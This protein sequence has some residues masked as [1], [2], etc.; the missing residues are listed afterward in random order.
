MDSPEGGSDRGRARWEPFLLS[1]GTIALL[2]L[3]TILARAGYKFPQTRSVDIVSS[4][5]PSVALPPHRISALEDSVEAPAA[6]LAARHA[7]DLS[8]LD[9]AGVVPLEDAD[10]ALAPFFRAVREGRTARVAWFGDSFTEGDILVGD[11]REMLQRAFGGSGVGLLAPTTPVARYRP[12]VLQTFSDDWRE[13][14]LVSRGGPWIP[15]GVTGR[16]SMPRIGTDSSFGSWVRMESGDRPGTKRFD[17]LR[18]LCAGGGNP[19]DSARISWGDGSVTIGLGAGTELRAQTISLPSVS[20]VRVA[21]QVRDTL[22]VQGLSLEGEPAGVLIDNLSFR[23]NSGVGVLKIPAGI[24]ARTQRE[25]GYSLVVLQFGANVADTTM[26]GYGWYRDRLI[27]V[28]ERVRSTFPGAGVLLVGVADRGVKDTAGNI[29]TH[30]SIPLILKAQR[31]AAIRT[32][33][34]FWDLRK[35]MGG[36]NAMARWAAAGMVAPDYVHISQNG[37]RRLAKALAKSVGQAWT[38]AKE[39]SP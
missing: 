17:R 1:A 11:L 35:A 9:T 27:E 36:D 20:S 4:L 29:V 37:G 7:V 34:G 12:T 19:L 14:N 13:R 8:W 39:P 5:R 33:C 15:L 38:R 22:A 3:L 2:G 30:P 18:I 6:P 23:G 24:M 10:A 25:L 21:F 28:V 16:A 32:G 31:E 26:T